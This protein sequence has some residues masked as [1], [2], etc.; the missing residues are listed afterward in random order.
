MIS[1]YMID[2]NSFTWLIMR[3]PF[4]KFLRTSSYWFFSCEF[5]L[6]PVYV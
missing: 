6:V 4:I 2:T 3:K 1:Y 5:I